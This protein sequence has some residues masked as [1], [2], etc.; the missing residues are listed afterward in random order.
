[1]I[2]RRAYQHKTSQVVEAMYIVKVRITEGLLAANDHFLLVGNNGYDPH[3]CTNLLKMSE[4][5]NDMFAYQ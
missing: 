3:A 4:T 2:Q 5:I 1:M